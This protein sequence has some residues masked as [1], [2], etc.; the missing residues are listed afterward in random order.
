MGEKKGSAV[1]RLQHHMTGN[2][3]VRQGGWWQ[4]RARALMFVLQTSIAILF[5]IT[6][7]PAF[8]GK[9]PPFKAVGSVLHIPAM[10]LFQTSPLSFWNE[11][12]TRQSSQMFAFFE[13]LGLLH[14]LIQ[15]IDVYMQLH[16]E[17]KQCFGF[18]RKRV[19]EVW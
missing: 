18:V 14:M 4:E 3:C 11:L 5:S 16:P 7:T 19:A 17:T 1:T 6:M 15:Y 13:I 9:A 8:L 2:V 10:T 12:L